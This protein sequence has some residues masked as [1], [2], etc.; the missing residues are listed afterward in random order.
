MSR[1]LVLWFEH[2]GMIEML[3]HAWDT[4]GGPQVISRH[5]KNENVFKMS[6]NERCTCKNTVFHCQICKFVEVLLPSSCS[7]V[8]RHLKNTLFLHSKCGNHSSFRSCNFLSTTCHSP[9]FPTTIFG[10][11]VG[12]WNRCR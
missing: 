10:I 12:F 9:F 2:S 1:S 7:L 3:Q 4:R 8:K 11:G 6:K 5:R